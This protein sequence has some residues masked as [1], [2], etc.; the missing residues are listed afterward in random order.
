MLSNCMNHFLSFFK[1]VTDV[2]IKWK[3][4]RTE[5]SYEGPPA[6]KNHEAG[7]SRKKMFLKN[8]KVEF[9]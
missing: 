7:G 5:G 4:V 8:S 6:T 1:D 3:F 9:R 2:W